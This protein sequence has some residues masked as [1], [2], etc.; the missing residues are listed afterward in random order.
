MKKTLNIL[1]VI[2]LFILIG[3][4][5][6]IGGFYNLKVKTNTEEI[7]IENPEYTSDLPE[8]TEIPEFLI[9]TKETQIYLGEFLVEKLFLIKLRDY[10]GVELTRE[11]LV[12]ALIVFTALEEL[13]ILH[14][15]KKKSKK[16]KKNKKIKETDTT[17]ALENYKISKD[18][19][20]IKF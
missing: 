7:Q 1:A 15:I 12:L 20:G 16:I 14:L 17:K 8:D 6:S 19:M 4:C 13:A 3:F 5:L 9:E 10:L 11:I 2:I 18:Q